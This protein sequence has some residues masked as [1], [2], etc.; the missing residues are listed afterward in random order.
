MNLVRA[1][2]QSLLVILDR[3]LKV[4]RF[5]EQVAH[6]H[7]SKHIL[8]VQNHAFFKQLSRRLKL[9]LLKVEN[10]ELTECFVMVGVFLDAEFVVLF[11]NFGIASQ[12]MQSLPVPEIGTNAFWIQLASV[13]K[14]LDSL[15]VL[16]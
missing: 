2:L 14:V 5:E 7:E 13:F 9:A 3:V 11:R 4:T 15:L 10:S 12:E 6:R 16:A 8:G 1:I